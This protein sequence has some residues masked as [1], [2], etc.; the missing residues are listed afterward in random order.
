[1]GVVFQV[2]TSADQETKSS[3]EVLLMQ[4][5][6]APVSSDPRP[7]QTLAGRNVGE[8]YPH[9]FPGFSL[10]GALEES[11]GLTRS[12][13]HGVYVDGPVGMS[14]HAHHLMS[15]AGLGAGLDEADLL[16]DLEDHPLGIERLIFLSGVR[17][18]TGAERQEQGDD[19]DATKQ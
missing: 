8:I 6:E 15:Q 17:R 11:Q 5:P 2:S 10:V 4:E 18:G 12:L 3:L 13:G 1:M 19:A 7:D 16:V 9:R 14:D